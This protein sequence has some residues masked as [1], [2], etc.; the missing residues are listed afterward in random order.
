VLVASIRRLKRG[1]RKEEK[2][3]GRGGKGR[4]REETDEDRGSK[5]VREGE[6][7]K[8]GE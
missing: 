8:S 3:K 7:M 6:K 2:G 1:R 5:V 4:T